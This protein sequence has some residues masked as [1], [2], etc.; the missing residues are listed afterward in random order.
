MESAA[1]CPFCYLRFK[2]PGALANHLKSKHPEKML[3]YKSMK[4]KLDTEDASSQSWAQEGPNTYFELHDI[5]S[6]FRALETQSE[7][8]SDQ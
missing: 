3:P 7:I 5:F 4:R 1:G 6:D 8:P 2:S